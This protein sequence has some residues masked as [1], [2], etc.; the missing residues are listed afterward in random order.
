MSSGRR[1]KSHPLGDPHRRSQDES[2]GSSP[3]TP[4]TVSITTSRDRV[5]GKIPSR[6]VD[7][8]PLIRCDPRLVRANVGDG[9][10][11]S[12][13]V[14]DSGRGRRQCLW[15]LTQYI[16]LVVKERVSSTFGKVWGSDV[17]RGVRLR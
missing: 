11:V 16:F 15:Y 8:G 2:Q 4:E 14:T 3:V 5:S 1:R 12:D 10:R 7:E 9:G 6:L 13:A 17:V